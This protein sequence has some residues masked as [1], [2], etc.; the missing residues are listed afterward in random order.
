LL[1]SPGTQVPGFTILDSG[2]GIGL[3]LLHQV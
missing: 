3:P 1:I 2:T